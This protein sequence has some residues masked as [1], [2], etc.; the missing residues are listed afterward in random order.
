M[1]TYKNLYPQ[2]S[3][4]ANL[5]TAWRKARKG[6]RGKQAVARFEFDLETNLLQLERELQ[7]KTYQPGAYRSFFIHDSKKRK[8]SAAPFRDRVVHHALCNVLEPIYERKFIHDS[9]ANRLGKGTHRALD[10]AQSFARQYPHVLKCDIE[11]F[12]P[13]IDHAVLRQILFRHIACADTRW[14]MDQIIDGGVGI[15]SDQYRQRYFY[16]DDLFAATR[17]RG[18]P[19]GNQT[20][21]F[22]ANVYLNPLDHFIKRDLKCTAYCRYV[23][24]FL[25]FHE[26]KAV[27][28][29]WRA[30][31]E[32]FLMTLRLTIHPHKSV[33]FPVNCGIPFL[34]FQLF[35]YH[36]RLL[37]QNVR[38]F[39]RRFRRQRR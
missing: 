11:T 4:F 19:I 16:G 27:L 38:A 7:D 21:Q 30:E 32:A 18:L 6:K 23:D 34:G 33:V 10:R 12:F 15:L 17:P 5:D 37:Q 2:L 36:R 1:K 24:D 8:I 29:Q 9:Y 14:L 39:L 22:W 28:H 3:S 31:L 13:A 25:L 20:S 35:P 26:D